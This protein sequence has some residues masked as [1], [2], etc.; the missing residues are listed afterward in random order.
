MRNNHAKSDEFALIGVDLYYIHT[1][2]TYFFRAVDI[3][4][5]CDFKF[6]LKRVVTRIKL[7]TWFISV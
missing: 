5:T 3:L 4:V 7:H 1:F 6:Y 2:I